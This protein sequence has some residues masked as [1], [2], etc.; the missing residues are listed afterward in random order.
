MIFHLIIVI[1]MNRQLMVRVVQR[2]ERRTVPCSVL[3]RCDC[4]RRISIESFSLWNWYM[5]LSFALSLIHRLQLF[6]QMVRTRSTGRW[7]R[8]TGQQNMGGG[9]W[10]LTDELTTISSD[11]E[12]FKLLNES[13]LVLF[14]PRHKTCPSR[15]RKVF[16]WTTSQVDFPAEYLVVNN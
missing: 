8:E 1:Q 10:M 2:S 4:D 5:F 3:L 14:S 16:L 12:N 15:W 6:L 9:Q 13:V 11:L 7:T